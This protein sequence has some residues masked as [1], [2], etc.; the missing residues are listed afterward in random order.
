[1]IREESTEAIDGQVPIAEPHIGDA[2]ID[3]AVD[4]L[5]TG[6]L[7][8]GP[9]VRSFESEFADLCDAGHAV[10]TSNGTT[11]LHA[12]LESVGIRPGN[13]VITTPF[14][15]VATA[16]AIRLAGGVPT[17]ADINPSTFNLDP[18]AVEERIRSLDDPVDAI[19][20]V[21]LYGLPADMD[22]FADIADTY[23]VALIE[24]AAQA[25]GAM[26][27]GQHVGAIGDVGTFS[28]YP[29]KNLTTGEGGMITTDDEEIAAAASQFINHGRE[30]DGYEHVELG[31]NFRM[32]SMAAAIGNA[33][34]ERLPEIIER[35][36]EN[37]VALNAALAETP[38]V[39][40]IEP[41]GRRHAYHQYTIRCGNRDK[42]MRVLAD[43]DID[44]AVYYPT[45]I[46]QQPAYDGVSGT[47]PV[48]ERLVDQVLS[49]PVHPGVSREEAA[50][51]G[52]ILTD[53]EVI[54]YV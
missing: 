14:S 45:P 15:F 1:M 28:F 26:I 10:A 16:N 34:L 35:R 31:H 9:E 20:V 24:D 37:A 43:H 51:I 41:P 8:D 25:H 22:H 7:A 27:D 4:V 17:F 12:A 3:R 30:S 38:A 53:E 39:T 29:T 52:R 40:P 5:Q 19:V 46:H 49:L 33:Q 32:T 48:T 6:Q 50:H 2:E 47:A 21:H 23:D 36:R 54:S 42:V 18:Y 44:S 11:A 13:R